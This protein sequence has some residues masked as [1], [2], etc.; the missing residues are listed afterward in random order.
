MTKVSGA[1][2]RIRHLERLLDRTWKIVDYW[3]VRALRAEGHDVPERAMKRPDENSSAATD[4]TT[5][6]K[7]GRDGEEV[8]LRDKA[9]R[10]V[11]LLRHSARVSPILRDAVDDVSAY[12]RTIEAENERLRAL[13]SDAAYLAR[14]ARGSSWP[15]DMAERVERAAER[16]IAQS[17]SP[18]QDG[19]T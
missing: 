2:S 15:W 11:Q 17:A 14:L 12:V 1:A 13:L 18:S 9:E 10:A 7:A 6:E 4:P 3:K 16:V 8:V 5:D 19:T